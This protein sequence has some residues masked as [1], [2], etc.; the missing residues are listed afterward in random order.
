MLDKLGDLN[1]N[2]YILYGRLYHN[3]ELITKKQY[4]FMADKL[5]EQ[6]KT[7][8][9]KL[10]VAKDIN[11]KTEIYTLKKRHKGYVPQGILFLKNQSK[12]LLDEEIKQELFNFFKNKSQELNES[13]D[14]ENTEN[15]DVDGNIN[16]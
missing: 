16:E 14:V 3:L 4:S 9:I 6:Y 5:F 8:Y 15:E 13:L 11:D 10:S 7:E 1:E 2:F 12:K